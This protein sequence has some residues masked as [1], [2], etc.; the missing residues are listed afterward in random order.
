MIQSAKARARGFRTTENLKAIT[1]LIA[2]KL[3]LQST[4]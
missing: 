2:G 1:Y 4:H 3:D